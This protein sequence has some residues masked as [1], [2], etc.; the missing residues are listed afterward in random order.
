MPAHADLIHSDA[1]INADNSGGPLVDRSGKV[2][3]I[4]TAPAADSGSPTS[5]LDFAIPINTAKQV[6]AELIA[7]AKVGRGD[8][9][10]D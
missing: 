3:G 10:V 1:N 8:I 7:N 4:N 5:G 9:S 6:A 2:V